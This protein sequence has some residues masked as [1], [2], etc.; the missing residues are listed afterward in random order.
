MVEPVAEKDLLQDKEYLDRI[1]RQ[2]GTFG[3]E[4]MGKLV[5]MKVLIVGMRGLGVETA[6][7]L[8]L[9]GPKVVDIYDPTEVKIADQGS[10]FYISEA[11]V[12]NKTRAQASIGQLGELNPYCTTNVLDQFSND[13]IKGYN[14]VCITEN[15][16]GAA[17]L[18]EINE[19]CRK[20][21]VGF[22]LCETMGVA[23]YIFSDFGDEFYVNDPDG[24]SPKQFIVRDITQ[25]EN[26]LVL[27]D[28]EKRHPY[29]DGDHV[30]FVEVEG[31]TE[32]NSTK[33]NVKPY[34]IFDCKA[35]TFRLKLD[36]REMGKYTRQGIVENVKVP[37]KN[38]F[39]SLDVSAKNPA[40]ATFGFLE[41]V[42]MN[43]FGMGRS[44]NLH[45][46]FMGV[47]AFND[48]EGRY[49]NDTEEDL[50]KVIELTKGINAANKEAEGLS[51]EEIDENVCRK[52]AAY[53]TCSISSMCAFFGGFLAQEIV[54][55]TGKYMPLNQWK[56]VDYFDSLPTGEANREPMGS[57]YDD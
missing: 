10:N 43:L 38:S 20:N 9:A 6:K 56:H 35:Y 50:A 24:I 51:V 1:S 52:V 21:K 47:H 23:G 37:K 48:Q 31:M 13:L 12:G 45:L 53:S 7:N 33:E 36:T 5:K 27:C 32:I 25:E 15:F 40:A 30:K 18:R 49:P 11:D 55:F 17:G 44:E 54:K 4:M 46:S 2:L 57:R 3:A 19:E 42:D 16:F 41:P 8:I 29:Q 14:V 39:S 34:E 22:L 28:P 26:A